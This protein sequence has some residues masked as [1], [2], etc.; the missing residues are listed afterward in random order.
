[1]DHLKE[2]AEIAFSQLSLE[3]KFLFVNKIFA[4]QKYYKHRPTQRGCETLL[5]LPKI[6]N[7]IMWSQQQPQFE[8]ILKK[9]AIEIHPQDFRG[10]L[11]GL[12]TASPHQ[13]P[14]K[15]DDSDSA[16]IAEFDALVAMLK[17]NFLAGYGST[18]FQKILM[19]DAQRDKHAANSRKAREEQAL[20]FLNRRNEESLTVKTA[21]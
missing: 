6:R 14:S 10:A 21:N 9:V 18:T 1:V 15:L 2:Q 16:A 8:T 11:T 3:Q 12:I 4:I 20:E 17:S 19:A 7:Y 5:N 13:E